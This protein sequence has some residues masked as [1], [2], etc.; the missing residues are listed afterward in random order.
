MEII[1]YLG[2]M[3][4]W[5]ALVWILDLGL[6]DCCGNNPVCRGSLRSPLNKD[7]TLYRLLRYIVLSFLIFGFVILSFTRS[8]KV[9]IQIFMSCFL[10]CLIFYARYAR[11][12][13]KLYLY[14]LV[15]ELRFIHCLMCSLASLA[16]TYL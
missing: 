2:D 15:R 9:R 4:L 12:N 1:L 3:V 10:F 13:N 14:P 5:D 11:I 8:V 7:M 6:L 16:R